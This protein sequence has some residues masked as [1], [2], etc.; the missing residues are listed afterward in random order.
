VG[1]V[2]KTR[3]L[4]ALQ[5]SGNF[6][7]PP[8]PGNFPKEDSGIMT[9]KT[10]LRGPGASS[11]GDMQARPVTVLGHRGAGATACGKPQVILSYTLLAIV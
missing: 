2:R 9:R 8:P 10:E 11:G 3:Q 7:P 4:S 1:G 6:P 5:K